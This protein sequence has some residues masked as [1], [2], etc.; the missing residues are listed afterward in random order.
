MRQIMELQCLGLV[1]NAHVQ[2]EADLIVTFYTREKGKIKAV[3]KSA[4]KS[5]RRFVGQLLPFNHIEAAIAVSRRSSLFRLDRSRLL[6]SFPAIRGDVK[7]TAAAS[8]LCEMLELAAPESEPSPRIYD[9][10][11][12]SLRELDQRKDPDRTLLIYE[13]KLISLLGYRPSLEACAHCGAKLS[14][15]S[16]SF[17]PPAGGVV[18][19]SCAKAVKGA[20]RISPAAVKSMR[21]ALVLPD[22]KI[23]R[24]GFTKS[25]LAESRHFMNAFISYHLHRPLRSEAFLEKIKHSKKS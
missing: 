5:K 19:K 25:A 2:G 24:L 17:S 6:E 14:E 3:A 12:G 23:S 11:L 21:Q 16:L 22:E 13:L 20:E 1:L 4:M 9:V 7:R 8:C 10:L 15:R 18:C